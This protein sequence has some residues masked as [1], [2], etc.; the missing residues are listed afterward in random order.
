VYGIL[1]SVLGRHDES[2]A[3]FHRSIDLD[4]LSPTWSV[5]F[6]QALL[7]ARDW[8]AVF[9]QSRVSQELA[10]GF[11]YAL[12]LTGQAQVATGQ[13]DAAVATFAHAVRSS[14]ESPYTIG[15]LANVLARA[16][17]R[18]EGETKLATLRALAQTHYVPDVALAFG[19]AGLGQV[20]EAFARL[21][22]AV[23]TRDAWVTYS[24]TDFPT[25]DDLRPDP[26]FAELRRRIGL[27]P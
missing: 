21:A 1:L 25:L 17:R 11:W 18:D 27:S 19:H 13:L 9:N 12:Q 3:M 26:R 10:P 16:G 15:L 20:D 5:C 7:S 6:L 2:H 14:A 22:S 24:L 23:E 8:D 4:P